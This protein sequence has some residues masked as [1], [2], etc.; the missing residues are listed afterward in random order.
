MNLTGNLEVEDRLLLITTELLESKENQPFLQKLFFLKP[1][2]W[3]D[4]K[5][6]CGGLQEIESQFKELSELFRGK[7]RVTWLDYPS[8]EAEDYCLIIF[9]V[10]SLFWHNFAVYNKGKIIDNRVA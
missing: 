5:P 6:L 8:T 9:F 10:E 4:L 2:Q 3:C 1:S 7:I